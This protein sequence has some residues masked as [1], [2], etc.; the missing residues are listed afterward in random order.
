MLTVGDGFSLPV[1]EAALDLDL[2]HTPLKP[3]LAPI[4]REGKVVDIEEL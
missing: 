1:M 4:P 2:E 3:P